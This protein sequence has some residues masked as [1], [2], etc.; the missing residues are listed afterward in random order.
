MLSY[1]DTLYFADDRTVK[2]P[3]LCILDLLLPRVVLD[4]TFRRSP[5]SYETATKRLVS[6]R[7]GAGSGEQGIFTFLRIPY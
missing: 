3:D 6:R 4:E 2:A 1:W 5:L 7:V